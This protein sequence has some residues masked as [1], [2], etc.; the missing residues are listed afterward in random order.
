MI[1]TLAT[2]TNLTHRGQ[3]FTPGLLHLLYPTGRRDFVRIDASDDV[4][5]AADAELAHELGLAH[6]YVLDDELEYGRNLS[7]GFLHAARRLDLPIAGVSPWSEQ[8]RSYMALADR[9]RRSHATGVFIAGFI[10]RGA[11]S[12]VRALRARLGTK[13]KLIA[14]DGFLD[15]PTLLHLTGPAATG[16]YV[17]LPGR[18]NE[19]LPPAGRRFVDAFA[20]AQGNRHVTSYSAAYAAQATDILLTAIAHS[21]GTRASVT[22]QLFAGKVDD[23][24]LGSFAFTHDGDMTPTPVTIFHIVGGN[25]PSTTNLPDYRGAVVDR[26]VDIP[27][28]LAR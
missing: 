22:K 6:V 17:S 1:S 8:A 10:S 15:I 7:G 24:V 21:D 12:L 2:Y 4:Q 9:I 20:T 26:I 27:A 18:P 28:G 5:G 23:G 19:Q 14:G 11:G 13:V 25:R 3:S 16:M